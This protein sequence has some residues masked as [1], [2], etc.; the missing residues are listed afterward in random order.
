MRKLRVVFLAVLVIAAAIVVGSRGS[1]RAEANAGPLLP[2]VQ[3]PPVQVGPVQVGPVQVPEV[4]V[5][6]V[7]VPEVRVPEVRVPE[8]QVPELPAPAP[9]VPVPEAPSVPAPSL[10]A[11]GDG[12]GSGGGG[13]SAGGGSGGG[14]SAG[15]GSGGGGSAGGGSSSGGAAAQAHAPAATTSAGPDRESSGAQPRERARTRGLVRERKLRRAVER[16][17]GC[18]DSLAVPERRV[19]VLRAGIGAGEPRSR[20]GV[21]RV[22]DFRVQRVHR[23]ERSGLRHARAIARTQGCGAIAAAPTGQDEIVSTAGV[24]TDTG[25]PTGRDAAGTGD[26]GRGGGASGGVRGASESRPPAHYIPSPTEGGVALGLGVVLVL[27][28]AT[29]GFA[30][31]FVRDRLRHG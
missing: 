19:L 26:G 23:L 28:A 16:L 17:R 21:A 27:L 4:R 31:P 2:Q 5:P 11:G 25:G 7:Q 3:T 9:K 13:G 6:E 20:R 12:G 10:P 1:G 14:G 29:A 30:T 8:V 24:A 22:L 15:G 18:L